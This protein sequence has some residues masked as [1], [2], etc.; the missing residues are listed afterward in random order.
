[1]AEP[2]TADHQAETDVGSP[3]PSAEVQDLEQMDTHDVL[4]ESKDNPL[5]CC[6]DALFL[7]QEKD[8]AAGENAPQA[9]VVMHKT[10][11]G[12]TSPATEEDGEALTAEPSS[13]SS[14]ESK[15]PAADGDEEEIDL[16]QAKGEYQGGND[17]QLVSPM[18]QKNEAPPEN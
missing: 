9:M 16:E 8:A 5:V 3:E 1:M 6:D 12:S 10:E 2:T 13:S 17:V 4:D 11:L 14:M 15:D 18:A 7:L